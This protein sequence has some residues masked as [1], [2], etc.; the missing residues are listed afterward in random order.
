MQGDSV[1]FLDDAEMNR[2]VTSGYVVLGD[3]IR[4]MST[5]VDASD[6][7]FQPVENTPVT[8]TRYVAL[9]IDP[10]QYE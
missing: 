7:S 9:E 8:D 1:A 4:H 6:P 10:M 3:K 2:V 5:D